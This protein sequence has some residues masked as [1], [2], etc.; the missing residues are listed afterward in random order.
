MINKHENISVGVY[1]DDV[2]V[3]GWKL[4]GWSD[5]TERMADEETA[6]LVKKDVIVGCLA[7]FC[8]SL[9]TYL[10]VAM[11]TSISRLNF[12]HL[13]MQW[14][15]SNKWSTESSAV[16]RPLFRALVVGWGLLRVPAWERPRKCEGR[17]PRCTD[18]TTIFFSRINKPANGEGPLYFLEWRFSVILPTLYKP[19]DPTCTIGSRRQNSAAISHPC[20]PASPLESLVVTTRCLWWLN[21][22][23]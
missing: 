12:R 4:S 19:W 7:F 22:G 13:S 11:T 3:P 14:P 9:Y 8:M 15:T 16:W 1:C 21:Q 5:D 18:V 6:D 23:V 2:G 17:M 10:Y 20:F